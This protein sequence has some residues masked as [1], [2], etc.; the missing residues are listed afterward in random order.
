MD[1]KPRVVGEEGGVDVEEAAVPGLH[2]PG[3][4]E[5]HEAREEDE[6]H[7]PRR[8]KPQG[9]LLKG[10]P[11]PPGEGQGLYPPPPCPLQGQGLGVVG[12][13]Q[14]HLPQGVPFGE[15]LEE[16][17][18]FVPLPEAK[19]AIRAGRPKGKGVT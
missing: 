4:E 19:T 1:V 16:G 5:A 2:E 14:D 12:D 7:P 3:G 18:G 9:L 15:G 10:P 8:Q 11:P 6:V 13:H 17:L